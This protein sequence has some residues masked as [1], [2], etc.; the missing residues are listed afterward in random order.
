MSEN[1]RSRGN[2]PPAPLRAD[3]VLFPGKVMRRYH[4]GGIASG[5]LAELPQTAAALGLALR[6]SHPFSAQ[7]PHR[8][9][10]SASQDPISLQQAMQD[11]R[12]SCAW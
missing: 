3:G 4:I 11:Q 6:D 10:S 7:L 8:L 1:R 5:D 2:D 9:C 12:I